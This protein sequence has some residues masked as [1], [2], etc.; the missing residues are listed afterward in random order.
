MN[1]LVHYY[2][3][4]H[5]IGGAE[6]VALNQCAEFLRQG[7]SITILT[8]DVGEQSEIFRE[9]L[10][11][12]P[13]V[14]L[15]EL[16]FECP[17]KTDDTWTDIN[18]ESFV[19]GRIAAEGFYKNNKEKYDVIVL[20][21]T[22]DALFIP[23]EYKTII[24]L[25]GSP[26]RFD[27]LM[28]LGVYNADGMLAVSESVRQS[29]A[30]NIKSLQKSIELVH[31]GIDT[32]IFKNNNQVRDIDVLFVGR[33]FSHKGIIELIEAAEQCNFNL[34]VIGAGPLEE[35]LKSHPKVQ[36]YKNISTNDLVKYYNR[37]KVF[38][39]PSTSKEGV[40]TTMLEAAACGCAI[41]TTNCSG[42]V[43]FATDNKNAL[44]VPPAD[45]KALS[46]AISKLLNNKE[47]REKLAEKSEYEAVNNWNIQKQ[48][49]KLLDFYKKIICE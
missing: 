8:A 3:L 23:D 19:F 2:R 39:C 18:L 45:S 42:M 20:H 36:H 37:T 48:T 31:N 4:G 14:N 43:D 9:F 25:H 24:H 35:E 46:E 41:V 38:A 15:V 28:E 10:E 32:T 40:L 47:L 13:S 22:T 11:G 34:A 6:V 26:S 1:I 5:Y 44:L 21:L 30:D 33:L 7:H 27:Y 16:P 29:W 12:H 49:S 17:K